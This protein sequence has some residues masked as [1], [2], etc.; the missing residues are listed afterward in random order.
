[1]DEHVRRNLRYKY[2]QFLLFIRS[3]FKLLLLSAL[4]KPETSG[5]RADKAEYAENQISQ[6]S[7]HHVVSASD[8]A[9]VCVCGLWGRGVRWIW[10]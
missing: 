9:C 3:L 7:A 2:E 4:A 10:K 1:M 6:R 8:R 5:R